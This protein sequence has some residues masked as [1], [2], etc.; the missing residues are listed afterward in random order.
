MNHHTKNHHTYILRGS[1]WG[2]RSRASGSQGVQ[3][4]RL[5]NGR[6]VR[7]SKMVV[8]YPNGG[9]DRCEEE[10]QLKWTGKEQLLVP[11]IHN[12]DLNV[13]Q[14]TWRRVGTGTD[15]LFQELQTSRKPSAVYWLEEFE[16]AYKRNDLGLWLFSILL[17]GRQPVVIISL[18]TP[19][20]GVSWQE[21]I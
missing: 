9:E 6:P 7:R 17:S 8:S 10:R 19:L 21:K 15:P 13:G 12:G 4:V 16:K 20:A 2:K 3:S 18:S 1:I 5:W 11:R 14:N